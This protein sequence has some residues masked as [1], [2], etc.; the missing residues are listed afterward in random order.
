MPS[1]AARQTVFS[2]VPAIAGQALKKTYN[3]NDLVESSIRGLMFRFIINPLRQELTS[4]NFC[5]LLLAWTSRLSDHW[6]VKLLAP[7]L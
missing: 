4:D 3:F 1:Q 2:P 6:Q 7:L 5:P